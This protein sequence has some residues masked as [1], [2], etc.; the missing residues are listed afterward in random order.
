MTLMEEL[1][2]SLALSFK[3]GFGGRSYL[4]LLEK[5]GSISEGVKEEAIELDEE[6]KEAEKEL[7]K[8]E[9]LGVEIVPLC[10]DRYPSLLKEIQQ[11]PIVLYVAGK[12]PQNSCVAVVGSRR[13]S[14][15]GRRTA[16]RVAKFLSESG[17]CVVSGLAYGI[18]SSAHKGALAGKG[19]TVAVLGSGVDVI[20]PRGNRELAKRIVE[21]GGALVSEFP[22]GT[23][24]SKETFPRRNR[25]VSGL[26]HAVVVVE[27]RERSGAN[28]TVSYALEQGRTVFAVPGNVDSPFS[29]GTNRLLK[30]GAIPLL[31]PEDI[32]EELPF[33]KRRTRRE[34]PGKFK[35][36]YQ[37]L[38]SEPMT[39]DKLAELSG[40]EITELSMLLVEMEMEGIIR[41]DGSVYTVC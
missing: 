11:P 20:H 34:I 8:A 6:L 21:E 7:L 33:L 22:L 29:R 4:K 3:K 31:S 28:I 2:L 15:Y 24:P 26:S 17:I 37:L 27:A 32:F 39:F 40:M 30:E 10:S 41:R 14:D 35:E 18:D 9:K 16:F 38:L 1:L 25:I 19:K 13:C 36:L 12:L 5:F 23:L